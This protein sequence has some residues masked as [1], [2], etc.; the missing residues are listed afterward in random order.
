VPLPILLAKQFS[1]TPQ[2]NI[3]TRPARIVLEATVCREL[4]SSA[5][6]GGGPLAHFALPPPSVQGSGQAA[7]RERQMRRMWRSFE[8][9]GTRAAMSLGRTA[10]LI[11]WQPI[12]REVR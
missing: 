2:V 4:R 10:G 11:G 5:G 3:S 12:G 1:A 9:A 6:L 8:C 7:I